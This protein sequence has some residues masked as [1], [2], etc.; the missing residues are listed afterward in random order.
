MIFRAMEFL[1]ANLEAHI[2]GVPTLSS[3]SV[4]LNN[5]ATIKDSP[6]TQDQDE[7]DVLVI[8]LVNIQEEFTFKNLPPVRKSDI[9]P[10]FTAPPAYINLYL[11]F[12]ANYK[13]YTNALVVLSRVIGYFQ[14]NK[15]FTFSSNPVNVNIPSASMGEDN[16]L[17]LTLDLYSLTFEQINHLWGSLGGK[18]VPF[19]LYKARLIE[20]DVS[21]EKG[22]GGY[23]QEIQTVY[24]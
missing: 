6:D 22:G 16:D 18:Q 2:Q 12:S 1:R 19:V 17:S 13:S 8:S 3:L 10:A 7:S 9:L 14:A 20:I 23:I 4:V 24:Q 11:L 5:I 15:K 21:V